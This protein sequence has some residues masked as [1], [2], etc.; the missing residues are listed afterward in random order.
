FG[1]AP[2]FA[3]KKN[4]DVV[5]REGDEGINAIVVNRRHAFDVVLNVVAYPWGVLED[6]PV[7]FGFMTGTSLTSP[8]QSWYLGGQL[9]S[10]VA[11]V[12]L[13]GGAALN[14]VKGLD[15]DLSEGQPWP[16]NLEVPTSTQ[17]TPGFFAGVNIEDT[18]FKKVFQ[19]LFDESK[20]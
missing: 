14:V 11:G 13:V 4:T 1:I 10:P 18:L 2:V 17:A 5:A 8:F 7:C 12:G 19:A 9:S 3:Y 15:G 6:D 20:K 16:D